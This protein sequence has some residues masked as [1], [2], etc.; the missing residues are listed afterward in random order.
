[1]PKSDKLKSLF[2]LFF[3]ATQI[4]F[5]QISI[6]LPVENAVFQRNSSNQADL[7]ISGSFQD[8]TVNAVE[9]RLLQ[10]GTS[11][12]VVDWR[13]I[14]ATPAKGQFFGKIANAPAGWFTLEV[15]SMK[16][17]NPISTGT[18]NRVGIGDVFLISGQSNSTGVFSVPGL[19]GEPGVVSHHEYQGCNPHI[20]SF[21]NLTTIDSSYHNLGMTGESSWAY[22]GLG[23][24]LKTQTGYPVAFYNGGASGSSI[25]NW[26]ESQTGTPT[27]H[28]SPGIGIYCQDYGGNP[29]GKPAPYYIFT[30]PLH[31]YAN[32]YGVRA[33]LWHQGESDNDLNTSKANYKNWLS[34]HINNVRTEFGQPN[35]PWVIAQVSYLTGTTDANITSAQAEIANDNPSDQIFPGPNT[36]VL[37]ASYRLPDNIHFKTSGLSDL[38]DKW[39]D[40]LTPSFFNSSTPVASASRPKLSFSIS[41]TNVTMTAPA[42]YSA[43][44]WV[45]GN[46]FTDTQVSTGQTYVASGASTYRCYMMDAHGNIVFSQ[47]VIPQNMVNQQALPGSCSSP[48]YLSDYVPYSITNGYGPIEYDMAVGADQNHDGASLNIQGQSYS[49]GLGVHSYSEIVYNLPNGQYKTFSA[50]VGVDDEIADASPDGKVIFKVFL[51]NNVSPEYTSPLMSPADAAQAICINLGS[52]TKLRLVVENGGDGNSNDHADWAEA[53]LNCSAASL[54][55]PHISSTKPFVNSGESVYLS[56]STNCSPN[57]LLWSTGASTQFITPT[58]SDTTNFYARCTYGACMGPQSNV[59]TVAVIPNCSD[60][61][62]LYSPN[63]DIDLGSATYNFNAS[64]KIEASNKIYSPTKAYYKAGQK[65]ILKPGFEIEPGTVFSATIGNCP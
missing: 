19:P 2:I 21:P 33:L 25:W 4:G 61:L 39:Q 38:A 56:A 17:S 22:G 11:T 53:R 9:A 46:N 35:M 43:Y 26:V 54:P 57:Q 16:G 51:D 27:D 45:Q 8:Q 49:R 41:G 32:I 24:N 59:V 36:D 60:S 58:I 63:H 55:T 65:V 6:D 31:Y 28:P 44:K 5:S 12:V 1:M 13:M 62:N 23:R 7:Y 29:P 47:K 3:F 14:D 15:R 37:G 10:A 48:V 20:P 18:R 30:V 50:F 40:Y 64:Q 34:T 52:A 42:G